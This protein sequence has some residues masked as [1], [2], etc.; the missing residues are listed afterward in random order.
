MDS[1]SVN[2]ETLPGEG[3]SGA[4]EDQTPEA[5]TPSP[6][7]ADAQ[8]PPTEEGSPLIDE[9]ESS[10]TTAGAPI[11]EEASPTTKE[12]EGAPAAEAATSHAEA[13]EAKVPVEEEKPKVP[14]ETAPGIRNWNP[15]WIMGILLV[16]VLAALVALNRLNTAKSSS[17][18]SSSSSPSPTTLPTPTPAPTPVIKGGSVAAVINGHNIPTSEYRAFLNLLVRRAAGASVSTKTLAKQAMDQVITSELIGEYAAAHHI[19]VSASEMNSQVRQIKANPQVGGDKGFPKW[20]ASLGLT[21]DSFTLILKSNLLAQKVEQRVA[22][23]KPAPA[24]K[25]EPFAH[26]RHILIGTRPNF[27]LTDAAAKAKANKLFAQLQH[28]ANFATLAKK[29]S[30]DTQS[31]AQGGD[32]GKV[33]SGTTVPPFNHAIFTLPLNHLAVVHSQY[34]YHIVEVLGRGK[35][36]PPQQPGQQQQLAQQAQQRAFSAWIASQRKKASIKQLV[37]VT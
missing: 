25:P 9:P 15:V 28:G 12:T 23:L 22:P 30:D 29:N 10:P 21:N 33:F 37:T 34:G 27:K 19:T 20:L 13:E 24:P 31:G 1:D 36:V 18:S 35:A 8:A 16:V 14:A 5:S 11:T 4:M 17:A 26:V 3:H 2:K 32:L 6:T 7:A